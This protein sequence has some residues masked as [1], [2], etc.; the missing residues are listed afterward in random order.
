ML[1]IF[2]DECGN[3]SHPA[4]APRQ[5]QTV[6]IRA[7]QHRARHSIEKRM[8]KVRVLLLSGRALQSSSENDM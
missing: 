5:Y 6:H 4:P 1:V 7:G 2:N 3:D 8:A